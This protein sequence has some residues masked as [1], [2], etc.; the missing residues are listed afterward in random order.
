MFYDL[1]VPVSR[2]LMILLLGIANLNIQIRIGEFILNDLSM[3]W[4][5]V[6]GVGEYMSNDLLRI[7]TFSHPGLK[8]SFLITNTRTIINLPHN[9]LMEFPGRVREYTFDDLSW[10]S[11]WLTQAQPIPEQ[12]STY[13]TLWKSEFVSTIRPMI[14]YKYQ[15]E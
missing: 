11:A 10:I 7:L 12:W 3:I 4:H 1:P 5:L 13:T 2:M 9:I 14:C 15:P 6:I 8:L